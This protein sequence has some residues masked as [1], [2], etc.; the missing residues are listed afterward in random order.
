MTIATTQ[1]PGVHAQRR[2]RLAAILAGIA[3]AIGSAPLAAQCDDLF[4]EGFDSV[5]RP[6]LLSGS[7]TIATSDGVSHTWYYRVPA[8]TPPFHG[9]PVLIWLH[10]DGG[11]GNGYATAFHPLTDLDGAVV[12]TPSGINQTWTHAAA[13]LP[14]RPQDAQFLSRLIDRLVEEGI[15]GE[16]V[17]AARIYLG[18]ESRGAYMPYFL[19]QRPSTKYR[20]AAVAVNA[21]LL[22]CQTGD[23]DCQASAYSATHHD[24][25]T[26]I[27][28]LHGTNDTAVS[29]APTPAFNSPVNWAVDW[30]VFNP[31]KF[32]ARQNGCFDGDN[33][34]GLDNGVLRESF[35]VGANMARRYDLSG[36]GPG[37]AR[38]QLVLVTDGGHVIGGQHGRIWSFLKGYCRGR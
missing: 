35:T 25:P 37:C 14:G 26:P 7:S 33:A 36:H 18:G 32:W 21:G 19:L 17:D 30:R 16:R 34:S 38:Y 15:D 4:G 1:A 28:H 8:T 9:R 29:P 5:P 3:L 24:A 31:M 13:D 12:V 6:T 11:S 2:P 27:L 20:M 10:G 23:A 22:Y